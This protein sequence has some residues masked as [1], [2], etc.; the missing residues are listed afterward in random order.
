VGEKKTTE[1]NNIACL[2]PS[3]ARFGRLKLQPG[4]II[5][6]FFEAVPHAEKT[7]I[8]RLESETVVKLLVQ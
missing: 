8:V 7:R 4:T 3:V 5:C 1:K 6:S 2:S